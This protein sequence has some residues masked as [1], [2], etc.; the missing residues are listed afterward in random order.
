MHLNFP[1]NAIFAIKRI[2][3]EDLDLDRYDLSD[4]RMKPLPDQFM[5][6]HIFEFPDYEAFKQEAFFDD[7]KRFREWK[8]TQER[9]ETQLGI[10][11]VAAKG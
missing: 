3:E 9:Y 10:I 4:G 1:Q 6:R 5:L 8:V 7:W 2:N 11:H